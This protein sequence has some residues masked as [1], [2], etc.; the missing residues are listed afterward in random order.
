MQ[1]QKQI[2]K[3][4]KQIW[5]WILTET[6]MEQIRCGHWRKADDYRNQKTT[7]I[8]QQTQANQ[9]NR[10]TCS[11]NLSRLLSVMRGVGVSCFDSSIWQGHILD[12]LD[13]PCKTII[14]R[15]FHISWKRKLPFPHLFRR[16]TPFHFRFHFRQKNSVSVS[17]PQISVSVFI[18]SFRF[19]FSAEKS[20]SFRST[21]IPSLVHLVCSSY[22]W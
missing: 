12:L 1:K 2:Q 18:F 6:D 19:H 4:R 3:H 11:P 9:V 21:F 16:K 22:M 14:K 13:W 7:W 20:E 15:K 10:K 8:M 17:V 5:K